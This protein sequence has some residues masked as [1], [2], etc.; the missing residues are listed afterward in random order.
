MSKTF[1]TLKFLKKNNINYKYINSYSTPLSFYELLYLNSSRTVII[2]DDVSSI[3]NP[4]IVSLLKSACW[5]GENIRT[6]SYFSTSK[7]L[8]Q[9]DLPSCFDFNASVILIFNS[10]PKNYK[11][12]INRGIKLNFKFSFEE[13]LKIFENLK[14]QAEIEKEVLD[15]V[16]SNCSPATKN[17]SVRSMVILSQLKKSNL[18]WKLIAK[19]ILPLNEEKEALIRLNYKEWCEETGCGKSTYYRKKKE[20]NLN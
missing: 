1:N 9:R 12:I 18:N 20:Y 10:T 17:L 6:I 4:L 11:A 2:F 16:K 15:Y 13:K 7:I 3:G 14:D 19:E 8:E 5:F